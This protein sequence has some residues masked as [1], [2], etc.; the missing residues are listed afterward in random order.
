M[1]PLKLNSN[2]YVTFHFID[3]QKRPFVLI[4]PG[5]GYQR[6]S[7]RE[8]EPIATAFNQAGY[9]AGIIYYRETLLQYPDTVDELASFIQVMTNDDQYPIDKEAFI[10]CGFSSG[11]HYMASMG[12]YH[13]QYPG[14]ISPKAMILAYPVITGKAGYAHEDSIRRLYGEITEDTRQRFS[15]ENQVTKFTPATF[16]FHTIDDQTVKV[17][18]SLFFMAALRQHQVTVDCHLY[19]S[20]VHGLSLGTKA[21]VTD[22]YIADPQAYED[23]HKHNQ[24]WF[25]LVISFLNFIKKE[26]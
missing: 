22:A 20:G 4:A 19:H 12:V 11:G 9:H 25:N 7:P 15:L 8:A 5:G 10:L 18:N 1:K 26:A 13:H 14:L 23:I 3:D 16:L 24:T 17:E 2:N 21:V 6:T